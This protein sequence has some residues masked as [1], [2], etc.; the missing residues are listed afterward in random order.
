MESGAAKKLTGASA[1]ANMGNPIS[2]FR[3]G[4]SLLVRMLPEHRPELINTEQ[5]TPTGPTVTVSSG[6]LAQNR[7]YQDLL[8][9]KEDEF[10]FEALTT[11]ELHR[12]NLDGNTSLWKEKPCM[13]GKAFLPTETM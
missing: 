6:I 10:N 8:K 11:S 2:W 4:K 5:A 9:S 7:T 3:D 13:P 12:V 1:N